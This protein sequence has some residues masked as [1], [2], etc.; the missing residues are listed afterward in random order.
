MDEAEKKQAL[1]ISHNLKKLRKLN[2]LTQ[3]QLAE[4][5]GVAHGSIQKYERGV[6][7]PRWENL[8][9]LAKAL[10]CEVHE[11]D[12]SK[13]TLIPHTQEIFDTELKRLHDIL[14]GLK[15]N[16]ELIKLKKTVQDKLD[17]ISDIKHMELINSILDEFIK[18]ELFKV[19]MD[20]ISE[21]DEMGLMFNP[22]A[23]Q[24]EKKPTES[25]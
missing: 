8:E 25:E 4:L 7:I 19:T 10:K 9:K 24:E 16:Q 2:G 18:V 21:L 17:N 6:Q 5:S 12:P 13:P 1:T 11:I 3:I 22:S 23:D 20:S 15:N 14:F